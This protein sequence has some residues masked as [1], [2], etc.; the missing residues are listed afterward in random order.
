MGGWLMGFLVDWLSA[1]DHVRKI[2]GYSQIVV[3]LDTCG[4]KLEE[5]TLIE[6]VNNL[7]KTTVFSL[8]A[9]ECLV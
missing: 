4:L 3:L 1:A 7:K 6:K 2:V 5:F 9:N 8:L